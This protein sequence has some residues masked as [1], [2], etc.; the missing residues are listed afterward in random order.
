MHEID[1]SQYSPAMTG[2]KVLVT[3]FASS[4]ED[5]IPMIFTSKSAWLNYYGEPDNE[6][7]RY[8]YA[9][10]MEVLNQNGVVNCCKLPYDN[11]ARD[12]FVGFKYK[13]NT[14]D[15]KE[16][17]PVD[18][19]ADLTAYGDW[20]EV[21]M[22]DDSVQKYWELTSNGTPNFYSIADIDEYRTDEA[23]VA[24]NE[25]LIVDKTRKAYGMIPEDA[26]H[27]SDYDR[28][29]IGIIP[30]VTTAANAL[31]AQ[32]MIDVAKERVPQYESIKDV[33]TL[34]GCNDME[35]GELST[36]TVISRRFNNV[37]TSEDNPDD[38]FDSIALEANG[39][40]PSIP[41]NAEGGFDRENL[42]K[43]G[44]VVFKAYLDASEGNKI[45]LTPVESFVGSL[46]RNGKNP[47]T[48]AS[49]FIDLIV[50]TQSQYINVFSN[51]LATDTDRDT[52]NDKVDILVIPHDGANIASM[53][54]Y[55][56]M[57]EKDIDVSESIL[58][59][60]DLCYDKVTDIN[61]RE[62]D[63]VVDAGV[64]NIAQF[65]KTVYGSKGKYDPASPEAAVW[66]CAAN[67][68]VK[69]WK[70][71]IQKMD[72]F[73]KNVRKDCM[74]VAD[75]PRPYCLQGE[76]KIVRPSKPT[77]TID[78][79]ILPFTKYLTGINTSYGAGYCD[80][81]QVADEFSGDYFWC[82]PSVKACGVYIYTD[83]N[84]EYWDAPAGLNRGM[85]AALDVAFSPTIKQAG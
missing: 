56:D 45:S 54:F 42:K 20:A 65:I 14:H 28:Q 38:F 25:I 81:F 62:L 9:A 29:L 49:T 18:L 21:R 43:V 37:H 33:L 31:Q 67:N 41:L 50:N 34:S 10:S 74:F 63:I 30:V 82:P 36:V 13:L 27:K 17:E 79:N 3:G 68:D 61:E 77:N 16:I 48:G 40:F 85:V 39:Y 71:I 69:M 64:S 60:L 76:K 55:Q 47:N 73:C 1:K 46:D 44:I 26:N 19:T 72:N 51:C 80:W 83:L 57:C 24:T 22:A 59:A 5:Y 4:G 8:F 75:G 7:E 15:L 11:M 2:T 84:F 23:R 58:K 78:V 70:T 66:K 53:G 6:A 12:Q 52:Y 32:A 35:E